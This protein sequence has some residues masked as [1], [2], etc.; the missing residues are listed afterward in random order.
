MSLFMNRFPFAGIQTMLCLSSLTPLLAMLPLQ[1][2]THQAAGPIYPPALREGDTIAIIAPA[3]PLQRERVELAR[4]RLEDLGF[5]GSIPTSLYRQRGYL[6]GTDQER[7]DELMAAFL[8]PRVKAIFPGTGGYG[9][10]R[11]VDRLDYEAIGGIPK[12]SWDSATLPGCIW[13]FTRKRDW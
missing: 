11:I 3:G 6:A 5:Q 4:Q 8:D 9:N 13:P 10:T 7:A 12:S 2:C 1:S